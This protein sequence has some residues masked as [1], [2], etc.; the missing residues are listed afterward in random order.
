MTRRNWK[1]IR[2]HSLRYA[3]ELCKEHAR[4]RRNLSV[5][6]ATSLL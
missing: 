3:L 6:S 4:E 2:P 1:R 5:V